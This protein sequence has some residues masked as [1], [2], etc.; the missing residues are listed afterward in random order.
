M[1]EV[2]IHLQI[3][4]LVGT[5]NFS[6]DQGDPDGVVGCFTSDGVFVDAT[7]TEHR[8]PQEIAAFVAQSLENFGKMQH[9]TSSHLITEDDGDTIRHRC[10]LIFVS[11]PGG[12]R[13]VSY[14]D[15]E[16]EIVRVD[17]ALRFHRRLVGLD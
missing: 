4:Q 15:Y 5:Y 9:V 17:G 13:T 12:E 11:R 10:Y 7:G 2:P 16:D 1:S 14:G 8:G 6:W 3:Q